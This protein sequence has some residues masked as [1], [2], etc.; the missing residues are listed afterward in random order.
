MQN[1]KSHYRTQSRKRKMKINSGINPITFNG[2]IPGGQPNPKV[3]ELAAKGQSPHVFPGLVLEGLRSAS[4]GRIWLPS[5]CIQ[6]T[7]HRHSPGKGNQTTDRTMQFVIWEKAD[8]PLAFMIGNE[9][10]FVRGFQKF[11]TDLLD[12]AV[13]NRTKDS[14]ISLDGS[15]IR[16]PLGEP[17]SLSIKRTLNED[18]RPQTPNVIEIAISDSDR[19]IS[20]VAIDMEHWLRGLNHLFPNGEL[21]IAEH[22]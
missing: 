9:T 22:N 3:A 13:G 12:H 6:D 15:S 18:G 11:K 8:E 4:F 19:L 21:V 14:E 17:R 5:N 7:S 20:S 2:Y 1:Q 16:S 10:D